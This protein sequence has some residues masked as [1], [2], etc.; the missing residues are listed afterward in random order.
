VTDSL[1]A[2]EMIRLRR[3]VRDKA[4]P[5]PW[6]VTESARGFLRTSFLT[7]PPDRIFDV[8]SEITCGQQQR[9]VL[10]LAASRA[11]LN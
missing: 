4:I 6:R 3:N 7:Q 10:E 2:S 8:Q 11:V 1:V 5:D 9:G